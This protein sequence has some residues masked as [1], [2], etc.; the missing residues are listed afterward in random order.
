VAAAIFAV[1]PV[2][3]ESVAWISERKNSIS[4]IFFLLSIIHYVRFEEKGRLWRYLAAVIC[5]TLALLAKTSV[6]MLPFILLLLAWWRHRD[7][8]PLR[9]SY[10]MEE[11]PVEGGILLWSCVAAGL[12]AGG[13]AMLLSP[14]WGFGAGAMLASGVVMKVRIAI[15]LLVVG[16]SLG[17][18]IGFVIGT[19]LKKLEEWESFAGFEVIRTIPFF[20]VAFLLGV[21]TIYFQYGRAIGQE[22]IPIGNPLQR[23]ASACFAAGF[24]LYSALWPFNII[25]IYPQWHRAFSHP[26]SPAAPEAIP[27]WKQVVPGVVIAGLLVW[28]WWRRT[29]KWARAILV[30]LGSYFIA[31]LPALGF[32]TM[33]YM[34][35][36]LVA[37]HFQYI[38]IVAV[39]ALV[40]AAGYERA[41]KPAWLILAAAFFATV[42]Y[43]NWGETQDNHV[44]Q[45]IWIAGALALA[46]VPAHEELWKWAW[47]TF[48]AAV[49]LCCSYISYNQT[50]IYHD[51]ESLWTA[52]LEKNPNTWQGHNHLGAALYMRQDIKDAYPHFAMAVKLK[53]ENPE[54]H[55]NLGLALMYFATRDNDM[56]MKEEAIHQ[57]E[58]AVSIKDDPAMETNLGNAYEEVKR[59]DDAIKTYKHALELDP[60]N[61]SAL[62]NMGYALMQQ[63]KVDDAIP[64]FMNAMQLDP[65]MPQAPTDLISAL[66][67][68]G[69]DPDGPVPS[70]TFSFDVRKALDMLKNSPA[71]R[72]Q[73]Q[74]PQQ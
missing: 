47:G 50:G 71:L 23:T 18:G 55:N 4:Q 74:Q 60:G 62:C 31:M 38:S 2:C 5:F 57:Y 70:G 27:Y 65:M 42:S 34:R 56:A 53:P 29:E 21:V 15:A 25:E 72:Q 8:E 68:K 17:G 63:G 46:A 14:P 13:A 7:L 39:I 43:L 49:L 52:T 40:V 10:E 12:M 73:Q 64:C 3:V 33:S 58:T 44:E 35:L 22:V 28:C 32:L 67:A 20:L 11:N 45:L 30:G 37:D 51:E 66:R 41:M 48:I 24:Y 19:L 69:I 54:S 36:T 6:V 1:H 9:E 59:Y 61:A 16:V 26:G